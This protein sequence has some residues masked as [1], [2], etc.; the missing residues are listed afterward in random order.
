M[1]HR[2]DLFGS[3]SSK[4]G[5][6]PC[7]LPDTQELL[8]VDIHGKKILIGSL[9]HQPPRILEFDE[10]VG[11]A[12]PTDAGDLLVGSGRK[13]LRLNLETEETFSVV[14]IEPAIS[15]NRFNDGKCDPL[16]RFWIG[17]MDMTEES[18][19]GNLYMIDH[20]LT[21]HKKL[22][23]IT[24]S[25]GI[26][27]NVAKNKMYYVDSPQ[28]K[29]FEFSIDFETGALSDQ[30]II[31]EIDEPDI[32][33]DGLCIDENGM[34]WLALWGGWG[35]LR[36]DPKTGNLIEK[37]ELPVKQVTSCAF[38]G[39]ELNELFVTTA[40]VNQ[41]VKDLEA[42]PHAGKVFRITTE[43]KGIQTPKFKTQSIRN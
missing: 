30:R 42:Q 1:M 16:G 33:P 35:V 43:V 41:T 2:I 32:F 28:K 5:E 19:T 15:G 13:I 39:V 8:W 11:C 25:N 36:I 24:V 7:W 27:W 29:L 3:L 14:E 20:S 38:G 6:G 26:D 31:Y 10:P 37:I 34:V 22:D 4:L 23:Q 17:T 21:V 9:N 18:P 40:R 12:I